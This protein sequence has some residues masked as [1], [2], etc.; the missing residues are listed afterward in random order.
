MFRTLGPVIIIF[1]VLVTA[2]SNESLK[3]L[4]NDECWR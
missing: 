4:G 1:R 3:I 2:N